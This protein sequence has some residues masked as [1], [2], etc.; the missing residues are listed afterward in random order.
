[1]GICVS[2]QPDLAVSPIIEVEERRKGSRSTKMSGSTSC[3][4]S[5]KSFSLKSFLSSDNHDPDPDES[6]EESPLEVEKDKLYLYETIYN[7]QWGK[8]T[9]LLTG[10]RY[11][12]HADYL[13]RNNR[14]CLHWA[15]LKDA[16]PSFVKNLLAAYPQATLRQDLNFKTPL[17]L[18]CEYSSDPLVSLIVGACPLKITSYKDENGRTPLVQAIV[19]DRSPTVIANLLRANPTQISVN[20]DEENTPIVL[21]F[22]KHLGRI[23]SFLKK[24]GPSISMTHPVKIVNKEDKHLRDTLE[25]A[26]LLLKAERQNN[27]FGAKEKQINQDNMTNYSGSTGSS[28]WNILEAAIESPSCPYP[29]VELILR[30][31]PDKTETFNSNGYQ[32]IHI[33]SSQ[34]FSNSSA[35][36]D[37]YKC[38]QCKCTQDANLQPHY[39]RNDHRQ[40]YR[41]LL[42]KNCMQDSQFWD[43]EDYVPCDKATATIKALLSM[44]ADL[45]KTYC[46]SG[47]LPLF[48]ALRSGR[49]WENGG[50]KELVNAYPEALKIKDSESGLLPFMLIASAHDD[51]KSSS[52]NQ[53]GHQLETINT[54]LNLMLEN[55]SVVDSVVIKKSDHVLDDSSN[56]MYKKKD[57]DRSNT[58]E[59]KVEILESSTDFSSVDKDTKNSD[60]IITDSNDPLSHDVTDEFSLDDNTQES[61]IL[62]LQDIHA[63]EE[64]NVSDILKEDDSIISDNTKVCDSPDDDATENGGNENSTVELKEEEISTKHNQEMEVN[65]EEIFICPSLSV[66]KSL[67]ETADDTKSDKIINGEEKSDIA[68]CGTS[69]QVERDSKESENQVRESSLIRQMSTI[70]SSEKA[71]SA[72][73]E[74]GAAAFT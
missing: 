74:L 13:D 57:L 43:Y 15:C 63:I 71:I 28:D 70:L 53:E 8:A 40:F 46:K 50:I 27:R 1:M 20:D 26:K 2:K 35:Y 32:C 30:L 6:D 73:A 21:F 69:T 36:L 16:P 4:K 68:L 14:T 29:F 37:I 23:L 72:I 56:S 42:C 39:F 5:V 12:E 49:D 38:D 55:L 7:R 34:N 19:S 47:A 66:S 51:K 17:H 31:Y 10:K 33:A 65:T 18:S 24:Q 59:D 45:S 41:Q 54:T 3:R 9:E 44:N 52:C 61:T 60:A 62:D 25:T 48:L 22:K 11:Y 64:E 58:V 67:N